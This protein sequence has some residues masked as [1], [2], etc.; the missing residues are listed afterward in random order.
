MSQKIWQQCKKALSKEDQDDFTRVL[1]MINK[2]LGLLRHEPE[3]NRLGG[4]PIH[5]FWQSMIA[6]ST[7]ELKR[8]QQEAWDV[9]D[10]FNENEKPI[11]EKLKKATQAMVHFFPLLSV[12]HTE[13]PTEENEMTKIRRRTFLALD[14]EMRK[15]I[16]AILA[17]ENAS[18]AERRLVTSFLI[19]LIACR[20]GIPVKCLDPS[21]FP[22]NGE[23]QTD[24]RIDTGE[25][26]SFSEIADGAFNS[27][28]P[29]AD[30][31]LDPNTRQTLLMEQLAHLATNLE[32]ITSQLIQYDMS[33]DVELLSLVKELIDKMGPLWNTWDDGVDGSVPADE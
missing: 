24:P 19:G 22:D 25:L 29:L 7:A 16:D 3:Q 31:E 4:A 2:D 13:G 8:I 12:Y 11:P 14:I 21:M 5:S 1:T 17:N 26:E 10:S 9:A 30:E 20:G 23:E 15:R 27:I 18:W 28:K 33:T 6:I 32:S